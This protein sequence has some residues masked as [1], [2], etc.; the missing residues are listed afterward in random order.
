MG[1]FDKVKNILFDEEPD[2]EVEALPKRQP[3]KKKSGISDYTEEI[4]TI[5]EVKITEDDSKDDDFNFPVND[6]ESISR[7][8]LR[9]SEY[10]TPV[11]RE[12]PTEPV[13]QRPVERPIERPVQVE[14]PVQQPVQHVDRSRYELPPKKEV[15][16]ESRD[17]KKILSETTANREKKPFTVTPIISPVY[18]ILDKNYKPEEIPEKNKTEK[19][20]QVRERMFGPVSYADEDIPA[21][22]KY[23]VS[24]ETL[25]EKLIKEN[26]EK[27][28]KIEETVSKGAENEF[29]I[30]SEF[31]TIP[32]MNETPIEEER[33]VDEDPTS[34]S[35]DISDLIQEAESNV[36]DDEPVEDF[37]PSEDYFKTESPEDF[38]DDE[39][40]T[41]SPE[42][43]KEEVK[44]SLDDTIETDLFNLIDSMYNT[45]EKE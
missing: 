42:P 20:E 17:Y 3:K 44:E 7:T 38:E 26:K 5:K 33:Y 8:R 19:I 35:V 40:V 12:I 22:T 4:D 18:G 1:L 14:R 6:Y 41:Y 29:E 13:I 10:D 21:P 15:V 45:D 24:E 43:R 36:Y 27:E 30:T 39:E 23:K 28:E 25:T 32:E 11:E 9:E 34:P 2:D 16:H 37:T 31:D